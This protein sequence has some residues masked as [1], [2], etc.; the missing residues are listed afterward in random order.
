MN[1]DLNRDTLAPVCTQ[2]ERLPL[3]SQNKYK[4]R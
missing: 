4:G 2:A 3:V 1:Y